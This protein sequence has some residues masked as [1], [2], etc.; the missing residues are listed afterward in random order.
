MKLNNSSPIFEVIDLTWP[1]EEF[2]E[3]SRWKLRKSLKG[4][5]RVSAATSTETP[6]ISDIVFAEDK[7]TSWRQEKLFMIRPDQKNLDE[8]LKNRGY[9]FIDPTNIWSIS[10]KTLSLQQVPP[11]TAF[12]IYP[13]LAIQREL[14]MGNGLDPSRMEI[15]D[16]VKTPKTTKIKPSFSPAFSKALNIF[17][18]IEIIS[19]GFKIVSSF[20]STAMVHAL[21]VDLKCQRQGMGKFVMQKVGDWAYHMGAEN[22]VALCTKE[23]QSAN[24]FYKSLGMHLIGGYHYR[25][26]KT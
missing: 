10:S 18:G 25:L 7:M 22:V 1:A 20:P 5:K 6:A 19:P 12:S 9:R 2:H 11:V 24:C 3:L 13:P 14:W 16:R 15:M 4:G 8:A 23:N 26:L 21:V 17:V